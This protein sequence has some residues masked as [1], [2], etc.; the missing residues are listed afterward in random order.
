M[1]QPPVTVEPSRKEIRSLVTTG[2]KML[3]RVGD[4]LQATTIE[5]V[6]QARTAV[7]LLTNMAPEWI[8]GIKPE[9]LLAFARLAVD[10][11]LDP[12][13]GECYIIH[14]TFYVSVSG[15]LKLAQRTGD[16]QGISPPRLCT[17]AE[18][19]L[20]GVKQGDFARIV[21]AYRVGW[22]IPGQAC[23]IVRAAEYAEAKPFLP[24]KKNP[25]WM[26]EKRAIVGVL[27]KMFA[28][29]DLPTAELYDDGGVTVFDAP[30]GPQIEAPDIEATFETPERGQASVQFDGSGF[31]HTSEGEEPEPE[32]GQQRQTI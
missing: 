14:D 16:F 10:L 20:Y 3:Q 31:S 12:V 21:E 29:I 19:E 6:T 13:A 25:E 18:G 23:G 9:K 15:R 5:N 26:A 4:R 24:L 2:G 11:G 17:P 8:K 1:T 7:S 32:E 30:S 27:K 22:V 28:D